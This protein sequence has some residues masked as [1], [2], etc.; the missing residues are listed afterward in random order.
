LLPAQATGN[1]DPSP[2]IANG[3]TVF[4]KELET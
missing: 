1:S 4:K 2:A 3:E